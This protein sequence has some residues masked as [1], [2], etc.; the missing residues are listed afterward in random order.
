MK[1]KLSEYAHTLEFDEDALD[2]FISS[3]VSDGW[4]SNERYCEQ[5]IH[6]KKNK[7]GRYKII[8]ELE[9]KGIEQALIEQFISPLKNQEL[10][11]AKQVWQKKFK[12]PPS[13]KEEWSKQARF[14]QS[15]GFDVSLIKKILNAKE[16]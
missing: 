15:R 8:R 6:A 4:L 5:F 9:E 1:L 14:L 12:L 7:F 13:S 3:L 11:Y 2:L 10:L 16:E